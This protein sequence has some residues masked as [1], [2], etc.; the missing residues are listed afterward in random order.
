[1]GILGKTDGLLLLHSV[2]VFVIPASLTGIAAVI[3]TTALTA[4]LASYFFRPAIAPAVHTDKGRNLNETNESHTTALAGFRKSTADVGRWVS[5]GPTRITRGLGAVGRITSIAIDPTSPTTIYAGA[6]GAG[7][8]KTTT[9]GS[10]WE[11]VADSLPSLNIAGIALDPSRP[12]RVYVATPRGIFRSEDGGT[13]WTQIFANDLHPLALD[14]GAFLIHPGNADLL[15]L[16]SRDGVYRSN[17]RGQAWNLA[18]SG[19]EAKSLVMDPSNPSRIYA[20][21]SHDSD[22]NAAG[23]YLTEN[24]GATPGDWKKLVGCPGGRL[25]SLEGGSKVR[26]AR[27]KGRLYVSY[28]TSSSWTLYRTTNIG[29]SIG[30]RSESSWEAGW[31]PTG[32][33]DDDPIYRR[34]WSWLYADPADPKYVYAG[35]TDFW[36]S[37]DSG[38][39]FSRSE[40]PHVDQHAFATSPTDPKIIYTG[41]DGGIY[42]SSSHGASST[43]TF[44]A[45]GLANVEFYDIAI[46]TTSSEVVIGGTQDNGASRYDGSSRIWKYIVGG[47]SELVEIDPTNANVVYEIGQKMHQLQRS[48][49]GGGAWSAIGTDL[50]TGC[51]VSAQFGPFDN[52]FQVH[53]T[54]PLKL[55]ATCTSVWAGPNWSTLLTP[56]VGNVV[57]LAI[58]GASNRYYAGTN[59]GSLYTAINGIGWQSVFSHPSKSRVVDI[60]V[61]PDNSHGVFLA[62]TGTQA[63]RV[64]RLERS[65]TTPATFAARDITFDL[66][67][68]L[69]V[70]AVAID[71][72]WPATIYAGGRDG[73]V[74]R[75]QSANGGQ[76][77]SWTPYFNGLPPAVTVTD[78]EVH[79]VTGVMRAGTFGRGAYEINTDSPL[80]STLAAEGTITLLRVHN[81]GTR[82]GPPTDQIDVE[83]VVQLDSQPGKAFGFQLRE[84]ASEGQRRGILNVLRDAFKRER[85]VRIEYVRTGLRNGI[86]VRAIQIR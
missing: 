30:G 23:V 7:L 37:S 11:P 58:D 54:A 81:V 20:A 1:M 2:S 32:S 51:D 86:V 65:S 57:R 5:I 35:G 21:L 80:G 76:T 62:F 78:L 77:W 34:L 18:L 39:T 26:L 59:Q 71:R 16:S 38:T 41:N 13:T 15:Y 22:S 70:N 67:M 49:N 48:T 56:T 64:Y 3:L 60:E 17:N 72:M 14:G 33:I 29:C 55:L 47:D 19:G 73:G 63:G 66:P 46:S 27:S 79:P 84:D 6:R 53:P 45:E 42:R 52:H 69:R 9:G 28:Q 61:D 31:R 83:V 10:S 24:G 12:S 68:G 44:V 40:G 43:W 85:K 50:P 75:G 74:Y 4:P 25:P 36:V 82:Y 8:W